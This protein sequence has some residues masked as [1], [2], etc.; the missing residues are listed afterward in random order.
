[1]CWN[2]NCAYDLLCNP[3]SKL[4]YREYEKKEHKK[5]DKVPEA[6]ETIIF[7]VLLTGF[8]IV[9]LVT[10]CCCCFVYWMFYMYHQAQDKYEI[11]KRQVESSNNQ[12]PQVQQ[13]R[14][15]PMLLF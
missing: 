15:T 4:S 5:D 11:T 12:P 7:S 6:V 14:T 1:M 8:A 10:W 3:V 9:S 2:C 13:N